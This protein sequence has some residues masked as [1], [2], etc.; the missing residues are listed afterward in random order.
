MRIGIYT[1]IY[2]PVLNGVVVSVESF[3]EQLQRQGH[4]VYVFTP[5]YMSYPEPFV[6]PF[7]SLPLPTR[8]P[9]R[10]ATPFR[11]RGSIPRLDVV[12][13]QTPFMTGL[14]AWS[15]AHRLDVPLVFT[16]HT[17]L[18]DYHHYLPLNPSVSKSFLVWV[19]RTFSNMADRVVVPAAPI[20]SLLESYGVSTP[21]DVVPTD[22]RMRTASRDAGLR[23]RAALGIPPSHRVLLNVGRLA[24]E[25][26][27]GL[28]LDAC[29]RAR[30]ERTHLVLVGDGPSREWLEAQVS[31]MGAAAW[32]HLAGPVDHAEIPAWYRA[33]DLFVFTSLTETQGLVV[34]EALQLGVPTLAIGAGG[35]I[36]AVGRWDGGR[37]VEPCDDVAALTERY[38]TA[39]KALLESGDLTDLRRAAERNISAHDEDTG[40]EQILGVYETAIGA[41][42]RVRRVSARRFLQLQK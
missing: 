14:L 39:L 33:A 12:H 28:L 26:N 3:R 19:S 5:D 31:E 42:R 17:R 27:L 9:Y 36:D 15:H 38:A 37:L 30:D 1:E 2:R 18:V 25:K 6:V 13:A 10:F 22:V 7:H 41:H 24:R 32:V 11:K 34:E 40:T 16:Y 21:I 35:V 8:T 23:V 20:K 29:A 4:E